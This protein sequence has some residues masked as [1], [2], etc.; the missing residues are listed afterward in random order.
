[1]LFRSSIRP[2]SIRY[3]EDSGAPIAFDF[4][5]A[6]R[7]LFETFHLNIVFTS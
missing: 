3:V 4:R 2:K 5:L 1:M 7:K 6:L